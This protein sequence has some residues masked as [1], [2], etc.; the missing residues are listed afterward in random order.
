SSNCIETIT[1]LENLKVLQNLDLSHNQICSL[2]GLQNH[3]LLEVINLEDNKIAE[4]NEI[5]YIEYLPILRILNLLRNPIQENPEYWLFVIF[6]LLRLTELDQKKIK[7]E[8][9]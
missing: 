5:E 6:M 7:V 4:L 3:D 8:E 9:K 2:Q 1:G